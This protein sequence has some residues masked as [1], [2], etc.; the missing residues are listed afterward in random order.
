MEELSLKHIKQI[1]E[2]NNAVKVAIGAINGIV[3]REN[4]L[5]SQVRL[6]ERVEEL[7]EEVLA[8]HG[9]G[10]CCCCRCSS[11]GGLEEAKEGGIKLVGAW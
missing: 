9:I 1:E 2:L 11:S 8:R 3:E 7:Q 4:K 5:T 6:V 10:F